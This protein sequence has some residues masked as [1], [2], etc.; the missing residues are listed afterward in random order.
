M[1]KKFCDK[2]I[3][4][5]TKCGITC[6]SFAK[7]L[8][9]VIEDKGSEAILGAATFALLTNAGAPWALAGVATFGIETMFRTMQDSMH[10]NSQTAK[11]H[12]SNPQWSE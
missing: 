1:L 9:K 2:G 8:P 4:N 5:V 12:M 10:K 3:K 7:H 6:K 11:A